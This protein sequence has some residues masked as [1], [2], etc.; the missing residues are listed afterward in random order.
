MIGEL[1]LPGG[2]WILEALFTIQGSGFIMVRAFIL[3]FREQHEACTKRSIKSSASWCC[4]RCKHLG[5]PSFVHVPVC[6]ELL[7]SDQ[8]DV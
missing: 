4:L 8:F 2:D 3:V 7:W 1:S 5:I 6:G